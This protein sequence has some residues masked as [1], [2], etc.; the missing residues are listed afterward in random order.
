M[1]PVLVAPIVPAVLPV[2]AVYSFAVPYF[3]YTA[4]CVTVPLFPFNVNFGYFT[5]IVISASF[6]TADPL[7]TAFT[8]TL[9]TPT[10]VLAF[11]VIVVPDIVKYES[12]AVCPDT[13][14]DV[15]LYVYE[16]V[17]LL[18]PVIPTV[19]ADVL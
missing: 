12:C 19:F 5:V 3:V 6:S 11:I 8:F 10:G 17:P 2:S 16:P 9:Y 13:T 18:A 4:L 14:C 1:Y 15:M 7:S